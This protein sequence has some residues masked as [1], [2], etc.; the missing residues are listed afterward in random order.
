MIR[1]VRDALAAAALA[2]GAAACQASPERAARAA[3]QPA[4]I[5]SAMCAQYRPTDPS[6]CDRLRLPDPASQIAYGGCLDY[7]RRDLKPCGALRIAYEADLH[8]YLDATRGNAAGVGPAAPP[9]GERG[10]VLRATAAELFK[11]SNS[12]AETFQAALVIPEIR[13][14]IEAALRRPL[15]DAALNALVAKTRAEAVYWYR[16]LQQ[17]GPGG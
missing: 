7:N 1:R 11:A 8:A 17:L 10:R 2:V 14:K 3:A 15:S 6:G 13:R 4:A 16:Y 5:A 12:D 9:A